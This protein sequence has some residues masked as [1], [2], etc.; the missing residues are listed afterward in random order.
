[1]RCL[2]P[3]LLNTCESFI[4]I[5]IF[6]DKLRMGIFRKKAGLVAGGQFVRALDLA[7]REP[8]TDHC[9]HANRPKELISN[10]SIA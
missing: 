9:N 8:A 7:A 5:V 3:V 2:R 6:I 4:F 10:S 1:M